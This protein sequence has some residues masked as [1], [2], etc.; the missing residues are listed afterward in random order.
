MGIEGHLEE[1]GDRFIGL[2]AYRGY[3]KEKKYC[4]TIIYED[5]HWDTN[6]YK[7]PKRALKEAIKLLEKLENE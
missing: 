6:E 4:V 1:L 5:R 2:W 7:S 3:R